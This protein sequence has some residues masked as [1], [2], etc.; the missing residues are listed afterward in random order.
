ML[1]TTEKQQNK[2]MVLKSLSENICKEAGLLF[3]TKEGL[4]LNFV[5]PVN[6]ILLLEIYNRLGWCIDSF[7]Y[8]LDRSFVEQFLENFQV[9]EEVGQFMQKQKWIYT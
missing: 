1:T 5:T 6:F 4:C 9:D 7:N 8:D 3:T 2:T